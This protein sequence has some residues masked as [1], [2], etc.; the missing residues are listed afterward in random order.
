[1]SLIVFLEFLENLF[2]SFDFQMLRTFERFLVIMFLM[3]PPEG[4]LVLLQLIH[5]FDCAHFDVEGLSFVSFE[6]V[7]VGFR[8]VV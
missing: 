6:G 8:G 2:F 7:V 4:F 5:H 3:N 1:M